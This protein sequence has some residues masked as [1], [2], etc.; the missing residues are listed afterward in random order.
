[1]KLQVEDRMLYTT[2]WHNNS[3]HA[4]KFDFQILVPVQFS[5]TLLK[6]IKTLT[7]RQ[8][9]ISD[10]EIEQRELF[11]IIVTIIEATYLNE[12]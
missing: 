8:S 6:P 9:M 12:R 11:S 7:M 5:F 1:M 4:A 3:S 2:L 10:Q